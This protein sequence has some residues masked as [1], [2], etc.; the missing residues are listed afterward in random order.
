MFGIYTIGSLFTVLVWLYVPSIIKVLQVSCSVV[1][2]FMLTSLCLCLPILWKFLVLFL[3]FMSIDSNIGCPIKRTLVQKIRRE[4]KWITCHLSYYLF[5]KCCLRHG[6]R[7]IQL[8]G[9]ICPS[10]IYKKYWC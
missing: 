3:S 10:S 2:I 6:Q 8:Y 1:V 7:I 4:K 5:L 9:S